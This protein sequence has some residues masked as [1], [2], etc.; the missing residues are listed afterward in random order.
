MQANVPHFYFSG[1]DIPSAQGLGP[2]GVLDING[3]PKPLRQDLA[4]GSR[5]L[6]LSC[7]DSSSPVVADQ[8]QLL[9]KL[10]FAA[11]DTASFT[12]LGS[13][14]HSMKNGGYL[15]FQTGV[16]G[17]SIEGEIR[18][19]PQGESWLQRLQKQPLQLTPRARWAIFNEPLGAFQP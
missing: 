4:M 10:N 15:D 3:H 7:P 9:A 17:I 13:F 19:T 5:T 16:N 18:L 6:T 8:E 2:T 12:D 1:K 11:P 14:L